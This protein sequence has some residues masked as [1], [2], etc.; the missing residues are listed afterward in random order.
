[1]KESKTKVGGMAGMVEE[2]RD[3][4]NRNI[5]KREIRNEV[6][7]RYGGKRCREGRK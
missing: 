7:R 5:R 1:M 4:R 6:E 3:G 2:E